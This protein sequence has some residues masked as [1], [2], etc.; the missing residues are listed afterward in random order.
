MTA[1]ALAA[2]ASCP[3]WAPGDSSPVSLPAGCAL[4]VAGVWRTYEAE[5]DVD[6]AVAEL[7]RCAASEA[8]AAR[9]LREVPEPPSRLT[10][11]L[12]GVAA[13]AGVVLAVGAVR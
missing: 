4:P 13:G 3:T 2:L 12:V 11:A 9:L 5:A 1:L 7:R 8:R 10:W 6:A